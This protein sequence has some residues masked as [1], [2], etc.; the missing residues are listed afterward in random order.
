MD[1]ANRIYNTPPFTK[2][3]LTML[4][5]TTFLKHHFP[6]LSVHFYFAFSIKKIT[7]E[8]QIWR[9]FTN[10]LL[11][12]HLNVGFAFLLFNLFM[13]LS[14]IETEARSKRKVSEFAGFLFYICIFIIIMQFFIKIVLG[15]TE[16]RSLIEELTY[17]FFA[18][19]SYREPDIQTRALLI[20]PIKN[21]YSP[22]AMML[23]SL[24]TGQS[25][26]RSFIGI[27]AGYLYVLLNDIMMQKKGFS[28][29]IVPTIIKI[30]VF[31]ESNIKNN[32]KKEEKKQKVKEDIINLSPNDNT[33]VAY[34]ERG[35]VAEGNEFNASPVEGQVPRWE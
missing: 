8:F 25:I 2:Y 22:A 16:S 10:F 23:Y 27:L 17:S 31:K 4:V 28:L 29:L 15:I 35:S 20:F 32:E 21:A 3:Y 9:F 19:S 13:N 1:I 34:R 6:I 11:G 30:K 18:I 7:T 14:K 26:L 24:V 12:G 5:I 33:N